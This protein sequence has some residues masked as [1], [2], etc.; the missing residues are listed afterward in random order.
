MKKLLFVI[1]GFS[2]LSLTSCDGNFRTSTPATTVDTA[3]P[4][5]VAIPTTTT[6]TVVSKPEEEDTATEY[7]YKYRDANDATNAGVFSSSNIYHKGDF[8]FADDGTTILEVL[9]ERKII[10]E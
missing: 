9:S 5:A 8:T 3:K 6:L 4:A 1:I 2:I 10:K 7:V